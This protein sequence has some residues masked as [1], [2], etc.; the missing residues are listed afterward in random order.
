MINR[1]SHL[2]A[3]LLVLITS[4]AYGE[5]TSAKPPRAL[6]PVEVDGKYGYIDKTGQMVIDPKFD[7]ASNFSE[8]MARI[9]VGDYEDGAFGYIDTTG[10]LVIEA[11]FKGAGIFSEGVA[12][13]RD[14]KGLGVIDKQGKYI[15][16]L[17]SVDEDA[18]IEGFS[19]GLAAVALKWK[20][21][22]GFYYGF[23]DHQGKVIIPAKYHNARNF[24]EGLAAV[25]VYG[26][27]GK[28]FGLFGFI[29]KSDHLVI[30]PIYKRAK[31]FHQ[32]LAAVYTG[33][34][35]ALSG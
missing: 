27:G 14:D 26:S 32:G 7:G 28:R 25:R 6:F 3:A 10:E 34:S 33:E 12:I 17:K 35:P 24:S 22:Y 18:L 19:E 30:P 23:I 21:S 29:D 4:I 15:L 13:A 20:E 9:L 31:S 16:R 11:K 2:L 8:G 5:E 1:T